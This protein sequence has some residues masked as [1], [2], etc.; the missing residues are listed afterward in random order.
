MNYEYDS[1]GDMFSNF[2][3]S[4]VVSIGVLI[5]TPYTIYKWKADPVV[6]QSQTE[7]TNVANNRSPELPPPSQHSSYIEELH[8]QLHLQAVNGSKTTRTVKK[9]TTTIQEVKAENGQVTSSLR[10]R[11]LCIVLAWCFL[12]FLAHRAYRTNVDRRTTEFDPFDV[13]GIE[14]GYFQNFEASKKPIKSLYRKM[15]KELHPDSRRNKWLRDNPEEEGI[16]EEMVN[17]FDVEWTEIVRAYKTLTNEAAY[18]NWIMYGNPDGQLER[19]FGMALPKWLTE[20]GNEFYVLGVYGVLF[21]IMLPAVVV[22]Q[23][24]KLSESLA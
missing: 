23:I 24:R 11:R 15:S 13:F 9:T 7:E 22:Y 14:R 21:G 18:N 19:S 5:L 3:I 17:E 8:R 16:P 6:T 1:Q 4:L 20:K 2:V 12:G 10:F